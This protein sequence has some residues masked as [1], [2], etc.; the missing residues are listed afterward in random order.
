MLPLL[1]QVQSN[2][3]RDPQQVL[4]D[5]G[6]RGEATF[7]ALETRGID[8]Y[9]S[10]AREGLEGPVPAEALK[11]TCRMAQKLASENGKR[12]YRRRKA[13]VEPVVGWIKSV[14]GFRHFSFRG[15]EKNRREW[16]LVCLAVNLK[17]Y[18]V[19]QAAS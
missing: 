16:A 2:L 4:A 18:H 6:Y 5:A 1:D 13:I 3:G 10:L 15:Q 17:R 8:A 11:A 12:R 9:I 19:L 7:Q 14:L